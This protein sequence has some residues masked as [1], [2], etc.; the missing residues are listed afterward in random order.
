MT[1]REAFKQAEKHQSKLTPEYIS[2]L[3]GLSSPKIWHL[4]NILCSE[5]DTYLEIGTYMGSSLMAALY[6]NSH[7]NAVAVDN[8][9]LKPKTRGHFLHNTKDLKF[10]FFE[11]DCFSIDPGKLPKFSLYFFDGEHSYESQK[12][13]ITHFLP[14]MKD[15]FIYIV[16]DWNNEPVRNGTLDAIDECGLDILELEER[17]NRLMKDV[18]GWWCGIAAF[19]LK[20][21]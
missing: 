10:T 20:K 17:R 19:K 11:Q 12:K 16:D 3:N 15:E 6:Q 7:V 18:A 9:C 14:A 4:L 5:S 21:K 2:T 1:L 8:F 13:A